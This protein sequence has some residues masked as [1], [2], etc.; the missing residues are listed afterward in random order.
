M[1]SSLKLW[2]CAKASLGLRD[3]VS[4]IEFVG[5]F[6]NAGGSFSDRDSGLTGEALDDSRIARC[7]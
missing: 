1:P 4:R 6:F 2:T 5:V 3:A 7:S